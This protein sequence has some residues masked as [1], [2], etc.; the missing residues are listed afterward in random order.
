MKKTD[1]SRVK[2]REPYE[3]P[4][5][6]VIRLTADEVLAVGCKSPAGAFNVGLPSCGIMQC[7]ERGS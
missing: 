5:L 4:E 2:G 3:K 7:F 6:H 1:D